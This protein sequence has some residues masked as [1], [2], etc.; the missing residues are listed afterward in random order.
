MLEWIAGPPVRVAVN[1]WLD[2]RHPAPRAAVSSEATLGAVPEDED[3]Q[4]EAVKLQTEDGR[5]SAEPERRLRE[6]LDLKAP[7]A[8]GVDCALQGDVVLIDFGLAYQNSMD[9]DRAVDLY[10]LER[11]YGSTHPRAESLFPELLEG[12]K[13]ALPAKQSTL[14][15]RK[16][17]DVRMRG[18]KR[19][20]VG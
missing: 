19:S 20:M 16:L 9:E 4:Q 8:Q 17:E 10:V 14:V 11:A 6:D 1:N 2:R 3:Q 5:P 18:R 7:H 12:Y 13:E 15:L